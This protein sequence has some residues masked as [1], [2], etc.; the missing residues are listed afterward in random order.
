MNSA[1][2]PVACLFSVL[3]ILCAC[4]LPFRIAFLCPS[5]LL[6]APFLRR[7]LCNS[8]P[9]RL[10]QSVLKTMQSSLSSCP[11]FRT[12]ACVAAWPCPGDYLP[13]S[14]RARQRPPPPFLLCDYS[15]N[16]LTRPC[17]YFACRISAISQYLFTPAR[18]LLP[19]GNSLPQP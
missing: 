16:T 9:R 14:A 1:I 17:H 19:Q 15:P 12:F 3:C 18:T 7:C 4:P 5:L 11:C 6:C 10:P 8:S 13:P 2:Q